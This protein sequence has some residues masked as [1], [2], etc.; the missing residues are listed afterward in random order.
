MASQSRPLPEVL[1]EFRQTFQRV[2]ERVAALP[3]EDLI[4]PTRFGWLKG[5]AHWKLVAG[6]SDEHY[7]QHW[8]EREAW[9]EKVKA[10]RA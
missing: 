8:N 3:V 9:V 1:A 4:S 7:A 2:V 10:D 5:Q 6:E